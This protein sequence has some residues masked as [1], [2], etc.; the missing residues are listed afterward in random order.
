MKILAI[1][2]AT[3]LL[4]PGCA[5]F[6]SSDNS[7][8]NQEKVDIVMTTARAGTFAALQNIDDPEERAQE[9]IDIIEDTVEPILDSE[10]SLGK[11]S[12]NLIL[13]IIPSDY[14]IY[15]SPAFTTLYS[16]YE[17]PSVGEIMDPHHF[18]LLKAFFDGIKSGAEE[19]LN[20]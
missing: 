19:F 15:L 3:L 4:I 14:E 10:E 8:S 17:T 1:L 6:S 7:L 16:Y 11:E 18:D 12:A 13:S 2:A 5:I 9:I 20:D